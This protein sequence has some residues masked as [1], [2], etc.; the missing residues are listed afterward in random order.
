MFAATGLFK[1]ARVLA[2]EWPK[3]AFDA[4]SFDE[5]L[6]SLYGSS[7]VADSDKIKIKAQLQAEDGAN[8]PFAVQ[9]DM[10]NVEALSLYV[11]KNDPPLIASLLLTG[12]APYFSARIKMAESSDVIVVA[13]A[14]GKLYTARS[15]IKVTVGGCG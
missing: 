11:A 14:G 2:A 9:M 13:R 12:A 15:N 5:A 4:G 8:V 6:K 3:P 1:P 10:P 7:Q